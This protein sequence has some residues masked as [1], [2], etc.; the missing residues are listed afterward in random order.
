MTVGNTHSPTHTPP[1]KIGGWK[2]LEQCITHRGLS[3]GSAVIAVPGNIIYTFS[4]LYA[5]LYF[6]RNDENI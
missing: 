3:P 6:Y 5:K 4:P 1:E 2:S